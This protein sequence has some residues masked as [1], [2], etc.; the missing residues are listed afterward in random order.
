MVVKN[1]DES[2]GIES[3]KSHLKLTTNPSFAAPKLQKELHPR[4]QHMALADSSNCNVTV[5]LSQ[6][7]SELRTGH[8]R[9]QS[10]GSLQAVQVY[11]SFPWML[12]EQLIWLTNE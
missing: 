6:T 2:H 3:V 4:S 7:E 1:G 9:N 12:M 10:P 11:Q 8:P 5:A